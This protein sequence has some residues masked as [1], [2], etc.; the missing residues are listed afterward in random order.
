[1]KKQGQ[2][3]DGGHFYERDRA[4]NALKP[5]GPGTPD[6]WICRRIM[7]YAPAPVPVGA[8]IG[9]CARCGFAIAYNPARVPTVPR[10]TPQVCMQ[11]AGIEPLPMEA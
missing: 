11:C 3:V 8:A 5:T 9:T 6:V 1:M 4:T 10:D 2:R 7:D